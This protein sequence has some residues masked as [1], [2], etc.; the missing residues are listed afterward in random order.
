MIGY[1]LFV[2]GVVAGAFLMSIYCRLRIQRLEDDLADLEEQL[3]YMTYP[4]N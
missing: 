2:F 3:H 1:L 4:L